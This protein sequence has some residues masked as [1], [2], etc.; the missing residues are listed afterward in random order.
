MPTLYGIVKAIANYDDGGAKTIKFDTFSEAGIEP[1]VSEGEVKLLRQKNKILGVA[2]TEDIMYGGKIQLT[3]NT[4]SPEL[5]A[6]VDGGTLV[7]AV[8]VVT[9]YTPPK[10]VDAISRKEFELILVCEEKIGENVNQFVKYTFPKC[11][12]KPV[13]ISLKGEEFAVQ[14][15]NIDAAETSTDPWYKWDYIDQTAFDAL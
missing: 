1:K 11:K 15:F 12:G 4:F 13:G 8:D 3:D 10:S 9:G 2:T 14:Q 7:K 6:L 5:L